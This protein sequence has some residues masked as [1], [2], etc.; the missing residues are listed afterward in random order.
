LHRVA[1]WFIF[2]PKIPIWVY[3]GGPS[4]SRLEH[5]TA[6]GIF[7]GHFGMFVPRKSGNPG[8]AVGA[9]NRK[10]RL[11]EPRLAKKYFMSYGTYISAGT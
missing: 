11:Y 8:F 4:D 6:I 3:L 9:R 1:K 10:E 2:I 7:Y 5:F